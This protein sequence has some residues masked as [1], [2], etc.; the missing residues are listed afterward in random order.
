MHL[1]SAC[2]SLTVFCGGLASFSTGEAA[3]L[4]Q[5]IQRGS[6][7]TVVEW[8]YSSYKSY[9]DPFNGVELDVV[10]ISPNGREQRVPAFWAGGQTWKARYASG[11]IG[12]H[13]YRTACSDTGNP[14]LHG[15]TGTIQTAYAGGAWSGNGIT[16]TMPQALEGLTTL[17]V[18]TA[19]RPRRR[20]DQP[21]HVGAEKRHY[22]QQRADVACRVERDPVAPGIPAKKRP[23]QNQVARARHRQELGES[24]HDPEQCRRD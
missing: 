8:S 5:T 7:H 24:L 3:E 23:R 6:Q 1:R 14:D 16:T 15:V 21:R 18:A 9:S 22:R 20:R 10:F 2:F 12:T 4:A 11:L 13:T 19:E 17:A